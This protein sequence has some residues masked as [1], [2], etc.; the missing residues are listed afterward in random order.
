M[1]YRFQFIT[2]VGFDTINFGW[3][4]FSWV[5][6]FWDMSTLAELKGAESGSETGYTKL[7]HQR[8]VRTGYFD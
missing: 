8:E 5:Y 6:L 7:K 2:Q 3:F 4:V 1:G